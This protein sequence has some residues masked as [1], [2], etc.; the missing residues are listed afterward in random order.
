VN[1]DVIL[2]QLRSSRRLLLDDERQFL[3]EDAQSLLN[4]YLAVVK[5][6]YPE[7]I[8]GNVLLVEALEDEDVYTEEG[9]ISLKALVRRLK[10]GL[11]ANA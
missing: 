6:A 10:Y 3:F 5:Y 9:T 8:D 1:A 4:K 2:E 7:G 11:E